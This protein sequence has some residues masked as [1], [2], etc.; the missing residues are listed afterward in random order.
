MM[1]DQKYNVCLIHNADPRGLR[2]G[3][4]ETY[5][6]DYIFYHPE[7]MNLLL[8]GPDEIGDLEI[9]KVTRVT[10][11]GREFDFLPI[12]HIS[13]SR[14][15]YRPSILQS[16]TFELAALLLKNWGMIRSL[17][18]KGR[19]SVE[20]RRV[21][22]GPIV[23][24]Y[25]VPY[26]QMEHVLADKGAPKSGALS[27]Y[28]WIGTFF[29]FLSA[30]LCF[31]FYLVNSNMT[32][33]FQK[34]F[35]PF[36]RKF[37]TLTTWANPAIFKPTPYI[38]GDKI[39]LVF[40]GRT[41]DFKCLHIMLAVIAEVERLRPGVV[42][43]NYIGDG[44]L[45]RYAEYDAVR[46]LTVSH[47]RRTALQVAELQT[48]MHVGLL[49]SAF[50]GMPRFVMETLS[51]GRP[52]VAIHLPQL[53]PVLVDGESGYLVPRGDD[54]VTVMA[55]RILATYDAMKI[56]RITPEGVADHVKAYTPQSLLS[57]IFADHRQLHGL[58]RSA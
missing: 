1:N 41:D 39:R 46:H 3:G 54:Q 8:I 29:E 23:S 48:A 4:T 5:L 55:E 7:D 15:A 13:D 40:A 6:R 34:K 49:T 58:P 31:R 44:D 28:P 19:Y 45:E 35:W 12:Y 51:A 26:V 52:A 47:G 18:R 53:E 33:L 42:E 17:L 22:F 2:V 14:N 38:F 32:A 37:D 56:G 9:G 27:K 25:G 16:D 10:F 11:R 30:A 43:F 57:K 36:A 50:E 24:T 20:L 21:E